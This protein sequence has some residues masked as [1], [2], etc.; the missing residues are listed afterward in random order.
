PDVVAFNGRAFQYHAH[1]LTADVGD[2]VRIWVLDAGPNA[3]VSFHVVG[4]QF[5]T[6]WSEGAY[7]VH[8]DAAIDGRTPGRTGAQ[9]LSLL[10]AE[11]GFVEL[12]PVEAG[13][14]AFV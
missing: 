7:T 4:T 1:P 14:Y 9:T 10:A 3:S 13:H 8:R 11:G 6:V 5:D 2:R 12:V